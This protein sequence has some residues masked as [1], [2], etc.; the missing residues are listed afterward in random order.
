MENSVANRKR[1]LSCVVP[2]P[3]F[4][5]FLF[6]PMERA[7]AWGYAN[8]NGRRSQFQGKRAGQSLT[9]GK[10]AFGQSTQKSMHP[11]PE[12]CHMV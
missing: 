1:L 8:P 12:K 5:F 7:S 2:F 9:S 4:P 6:L 10:T 11:V 3:P